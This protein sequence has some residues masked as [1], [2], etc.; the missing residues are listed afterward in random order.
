M[1]AL[2][3]RST[4]L[5][6]PDCSLSYSHLFWHRFIGCRSRLFTDVLV[7]LHFGFVRPALEVKTKCGAPFLQ[8]SGVYL[9]H[10]LRTL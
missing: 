3:D 7:F 2:I 5:V 9:S 8:L 1:C 6:E 4:R 10:D